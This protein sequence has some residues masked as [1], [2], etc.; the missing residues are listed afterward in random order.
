MVSPIPS[1]G[2]HGS[3]VITV[4][5]GDACGM[6][7]EISHCPTNFSPFSFENML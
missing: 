2:D 7:C 3:E 6:G 1:T 4:M 5:D